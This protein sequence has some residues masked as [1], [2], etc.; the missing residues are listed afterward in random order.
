MKWI[1]Y[2]RII[3]GIDAII[4]YRNLAIMQHDIEMEKDKQFDYINACTIC[5]DGSEEIVYS[6]VEEILN[7][8]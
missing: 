2:Y 4:R 5:D 1:V 6:S 3:G 8:K 7:A